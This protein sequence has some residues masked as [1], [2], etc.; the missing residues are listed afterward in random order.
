MIKAFGKLGRKCGVLRYLIDDVE[1]E[2]ERRV[3]VQPAHL[4]ARRPTDA[5][6]VV[7]HGRTLLVERRAASDTALDLE[8]AASLKFDCTTSR[9]TATSTWRAMKRV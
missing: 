4:P 7:R 8:L 9:V 3:R 6:L 1:V 5:Q 2:G